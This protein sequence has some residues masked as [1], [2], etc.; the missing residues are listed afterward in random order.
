V[1]D[2]SGSELFV[3]VELPGR[4][5][6]VKVWQAKVGHVR[7]YMLDTDVPDNS[8]ADRGIAHRLYGGDR[9][10]RLEQEIVLGVGGVRALVALGHQPTV[11]HINEGHAAF[12]V[13]ER[14]RIAIAKQG[15]DFAAA[16]EGSRPTPC[17]RRTPRCR[18]ATTTSR[19]T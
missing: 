18:P 7:L 13:L 3:E 19:T 6:R 16:I 15:I 11:W 5:V 1:H 17:L 8:D 4:V 14:A 2:D 9:K 12:Q 10:T